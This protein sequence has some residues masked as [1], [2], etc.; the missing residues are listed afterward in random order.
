M[1]KELWTPSETD[2]RCAGK[3]YIHYSLGLTMINNPLRM[4]SALGIEAIETSD[5]SAIYA[6]AHQTMLSGLRQI[7]RNANR[8]ELRSRLIAMEDTYDE[9]LPHILNAVDTV[10]QSSRERLDEINP[11]LHIVRP[12][13]LTDQVIYGYLCHSRVEKLPAQDIMDGFMPSEVFKDLAN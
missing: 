13:P 5:V 7:V 10:F 4:K 11:D 8:P 2:L 3:G 9:A 12:M 1:S 6:H